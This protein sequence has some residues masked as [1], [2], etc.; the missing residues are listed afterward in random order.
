MRTRTP[1]VAST[2]AL[3]LTIAPPAYAQSPAVPTKADTALATEI[4]R[5]LAADPEV[6][7]QT[8]KIDVRGGVVTLTGSVVA[9]GA[10]S[11][12]EKL[13]AAVPGVVKV[14]NEISVSGAGVRGGGGPGPI[15]EEMPG[16]R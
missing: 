10:K 12:A 5:R 15:P 16:A 11:R 2:L 13:T 8:I 4:E 3:L 6:N 7:A 14:R 9:E 1:V